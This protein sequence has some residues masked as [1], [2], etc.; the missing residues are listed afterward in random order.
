MK[1]LFFQALVLYH[2][3]HPFARMG[4][5]NRTETRIANRMAPR[6]IAN[7]MALRRIANRMAPR[8]IANCIVNRM[9]PRRIV[10]RIVNRMAPHIAHFETV[11]VAVVV[12]LSIAAVDTCANLLRTYPQPEHQVPLYRKASLFPSI[13]SNQMTY[14]L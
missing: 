12:V 8:R 10:N 11:A 7:R 14:M 13:D 1:H 4:Y 2:H 5:Y 3:R 9:A 6:R